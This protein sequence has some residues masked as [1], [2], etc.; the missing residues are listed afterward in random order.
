MFWAKQNACLIYHYYVSGCF[1]RSSIQYQW[2]RW[3]SF[4]VNV[5]GHEQN[6]KLGVICVT[7]MDN[8]VA[9]CILKIKVVQE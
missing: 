7:V 8:I 1:R 9:A 5:T 6:I 3:I 4:A 2:D